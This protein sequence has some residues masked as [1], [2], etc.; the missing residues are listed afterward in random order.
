MNL[1]T[2]ILTVAQV[3]QVAVSHIKLFHRTGA[4]RSRMQLAKVVITS[5]LIIAACVDRL[6]EGKSCVLK[7]IQNVTFSQIGYLGC[8][9]KVV[10][11]AI[12]SV[13]LSS[14]KN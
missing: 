6:P 13:S 14:D 9:T 2:D 4:E 3:A 1:F 5:T 8:H 11:S 10:C 12:S 7:C